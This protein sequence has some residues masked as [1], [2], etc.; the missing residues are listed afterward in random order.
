MAP[1][2]GTVPIP[3]EFLRHHDRLLRPELEAWA[4]DL[5][6]ELEELKPASA[7]TPG[8]LDA[9]SACM[10]KASF[11]IAATGDMAQAMRLCEFQLAWVAHR[12]RDCS[13]AGILGHAV[14]PWINIGR[15]HA[16]CG[17]IDRALAHFRLAEC[18]SRRRTAVLGPCRIAAE[19]WPA[20]TGAGP[21]LPGVLWNVYALES[22]KAY[23]T[24]PRCAEL[25][26]VIS[27]L[28]RAVPERWH[29]FITEGEI[30][31]LLQQG[32]ARQALARAG[33]AD[34]SS[35]YDESAFRLHEVTGLI[36]S[37]ERTAAFD[38]ALAAV[39]FLTNVEPRRPKDAPTLLRQL[40]RLGV[41]MEHLEQPRYAL[42][43][44]LRGLDICAVH[45]DQPLRFA[46]LTT[47]LRLAPAHPSAGAWER[48]H[49]RLTDHCWYADVRRRSP[50]RALPRAPFRALGAAV[51]AAATAGGGA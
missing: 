22:I 46:F 25:P 3:G 16:L 9:V 23:L 45:D 10:N 32:K 36:L 21:D 17:D 15:L 48:E 42:A 37:Q 29:G 7:S 47:A 41:L 50:R 40:R 11:V 51:E 5:C 26:A 2:A 18:L 4:E 49:R 38:R 31:G 33:R 13:D 43:A 6:R 44:C 30:L 12:A 27:S 19:S 34:P 14:Q 1:P 35:A 39:A 28:R 8:R 24:P 20:V